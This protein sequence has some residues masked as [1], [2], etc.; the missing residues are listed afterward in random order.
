MVAV[1]KGGIDPA[2]VSSDRGT[3]RIVVIGDSYLFGNETIETGANHQF[4]SHCVNWLLAQNELIAELTPRPIKDF[5]VTMT[6][7]Q[8]SAAQW[9]LLAAFP[10][11]ILVLG[12]LV[13]LRRR[14]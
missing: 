13:W 9:L 4:A 3:T 1:E 14:R 10:G 5:K 6:V 12:G 8:M 11:T 2:N 7:S